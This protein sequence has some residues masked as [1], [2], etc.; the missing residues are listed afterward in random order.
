VSFELTPVPSPAGDG[1]GGG[2]GIPVVQVRGEIDVTNA[3]G[4]HDALARLAA[5][6]LVVDLG[7]VGYFD[8]AGFAVLDRLLSQA[9]VA[10]V[11]PPGSVVR[12]AMSLLNLPFHDS[13]D[14]AQTALATC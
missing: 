12:A 6:A 4:L 8:S 5:P 9:P 13:I 1:P 7:S 3:G 14:A 10:V 11:A 2:P